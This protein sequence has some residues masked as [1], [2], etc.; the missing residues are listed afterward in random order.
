MDNKQNADFDDRVSLTLYHASD[1]IVR[2]LDILY[3]GPRT[4]CDF[5]P[6]FYLAENKY[7]AEEWVVQKKTPVINI[8][9]LAA[10]KNDVLYLNGTDW[11]KV[12]VGFREMKYAINFSSPIICG[13]IA[14]DRMNDALPIFIRGIIG[15]IR[16]IKC[17]DYCNLGNQYMLRVPSVDITHVDSYQL[18]GESLKAAV[19][20]IQARRK[21]I[22][23]HIH[24]IYEEQQQGEKFF[25][26]YLADGDYVER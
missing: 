21:R 19:S 15:D 26:H 3:P 1:H 2:P 23:Q 7:T 18:Q 16:L 13:P 8:Y 22:N 20:R 17:L 6:G 10:N 11:L 12:I 4:N 25:R 9:Q 5:G 24:T 14:N